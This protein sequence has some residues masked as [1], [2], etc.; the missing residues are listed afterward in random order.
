MRHRRTGLKRRYGR[1][2]GSGMKFKDLNVGDTF[3]FISP[4]SNLNS[5]YSR[6]TK[7]G[8]RSYTWQ[9]HIDG[10]T[11]KS[12]VGTANVLVYHVNTEAQLPL[13][14]P[15]LIPQPQKRRRA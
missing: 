4:N 12:R 9:S 15:W 7:I 11:L 2:T 3:D 10:S 5:F 6:C 14:K 8:P 1:S 13:A